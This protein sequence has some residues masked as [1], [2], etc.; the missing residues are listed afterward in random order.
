[1]KLLVVGGSGFTGGYVLREAARAGHQVVA[2]ARSPAA[3]RAVAAHGALPLAGD[4]DDTRRLDDV[5]AAAR[6]Q[7][8]VCLASLGYGHGPAIVA[9]AEEAGLGRAVFV[10][11]TAVTTALHPP[12]K[13]IRLA[14]EQ[15]IRG[16]GLDWTILRPTMIY[17]AAGDRNM[18]RLLRLLSRSPVL[19][20]P[21]VGGCLHQPVHVA[22]VAAAVLAAVQRPEAVGSLY[23]VAGP[24]P[25]PFAELLRAC[26]RAV[27]SSTRLVPVP[28][29]PLLLLARGYEVLSRHPR[30]RPEQLRRLTENKVFAIDDAIRDLGYAPRLFARGIGDEARMLGLAT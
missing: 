22:D 14:A 16:C 4:L 7:A 28:L 25:L 1:M 6:C 21:A 10:S 18:S 30:I 9:A 24:E 15:Q 29:A 3:T 5:F 23:N 13:Q 8:L 26:A 20:V 2:L 19:P 17:G 11:T 27:G 12:T